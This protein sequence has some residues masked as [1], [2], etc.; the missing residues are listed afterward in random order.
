[1]YSDE[2]RDLPRERNDAE[3]GP[4]KQQLP[5]LDAEV[6]L[7]A[8]HNGMDI[9]GTGRLEGFVCHGQRVR[10]LSRGEKVHGE[11]LSGAA[12]KR[13]AGQRRDIPVVEL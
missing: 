5:D 12:S 7:D 8:D 3:G 1:L 11:I 2:V 4:D 13:I 9:N 10:R 6:D